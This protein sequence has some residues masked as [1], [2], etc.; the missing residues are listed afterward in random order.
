MD[1]TRGRVFYL[2]SKHRENKNEKQK[3]ERNNNLFDCSIYFLTK[4]DWFL[5]KYEVE[6]LRKSYGSKDAIYKSPA[7]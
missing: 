5:D 7:R 4:N 2:I 6:I 1:Q 3:S